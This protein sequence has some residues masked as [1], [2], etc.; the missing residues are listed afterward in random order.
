MRPLVLILRPSR[1]VFFDDFEIPVA[2][3]IGAEGEG[4]KQSVPISIALI[5]VDRL[6]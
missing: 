2:D 5:E 4:F 6:L 1:Q 3:R